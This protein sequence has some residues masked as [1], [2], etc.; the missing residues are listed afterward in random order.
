MK[1]RFKE[2]FGVEKPVIAMCHLQPLPGDPDYD[3]EKGVDWIVE[4]ALEDLKALQDGGVDAVMFS[5]ER[6]MPWMTK[7]EPITSTTM[8]RVIGELRPRIKVPF[9]VNV[10]WDPMASIDLAVATGAL[11]VREVFTGAYASDFGLWSPNCGEIIRHQ[12]AVRGEKVFLLYNITPEASAYLGNRSLSDIAKSTVFNG[13]PD[14]LCVSGM[15]AGMET[16]ENDLR[17]VKTAV[18]DVPVLT[19]TG[20]RLENVEQQLAIA[21]GAIIGT[22]FKEDGYIW[23]RVEQRRVTAIMQK[24]K[25]LRSQGVSKNI[26]I[27]GEN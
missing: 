8:A 10:I 19:N 16:P 9:G 17:I 18:P 24:V 7:A 27:K 14:G 4:S 5:N 20:V 13:R 25:N 15:T 2:V 6:S 21:D 1:K 12:Y 26:G 22:A 11:F 23:N 3:A